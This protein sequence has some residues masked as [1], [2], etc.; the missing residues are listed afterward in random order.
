MSWRPQLNVI[1]GHCGKP[2][3]LFDVCVTTR[4]RRQPPRLKVSY[5]SCPRCGKA[6]E[7][8]P[9]THT[10]RQRSDF[11]KRKKKF[12]R[13]QK[14]K[15]RKPAHDYTACPDDDCKRPVCV[16]FKAGW[17]GG[18]EAGHER[19]WRQ[20]HDTGFQEGIASCPKPHK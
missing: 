14:A 16:A 13:D 6:Y 8:S 20:G 19:G 18:D 15:G 4:A 7:G 3:G 11:R 1:C 5:G 2:H 12:E 9:F 17:K 10:C